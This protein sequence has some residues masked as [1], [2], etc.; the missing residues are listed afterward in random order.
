MRIG[1]AFNEYVYPAER[2]MIQ[3]KSNKTNNEK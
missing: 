3:K 1:M 2:R